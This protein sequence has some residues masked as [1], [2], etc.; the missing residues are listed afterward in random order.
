MLQ[1]LFMQHLQQHATPCVCDIGVRKVLASGK[2]YAFLH[3][4][5]TSA[6]TRAKLM[7]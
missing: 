2:A 6:V 1:V 3:D 4:D 7:P 5:T